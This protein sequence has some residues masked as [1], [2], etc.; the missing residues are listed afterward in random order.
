MI[1][2]PRRQ[3]VFTYLHG[4]AWSHVADQPTFGQLWPE[5]LKQLEGLQFLVA[6]N[7]S[8]DKS[9]MT[10]CCVMA[11]LTPPKITFK[12]TVRMARETWNLYPTKLSHVCTH[13]KIPLVH[14][15]ADSD[16]EACAD[17]LGGDATGARAA[18][19]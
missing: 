16:A 19:R 12:C 6:H 13:L 17:C 3:F 11:N 2:P 18:L 7:A 9:V 8:F 10:K 15:Q 1:Q 5:F 14:H 4:I